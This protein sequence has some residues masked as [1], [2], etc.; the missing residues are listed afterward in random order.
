MMTRWRWRW[1]R[2]ERASTNWKF[3]FIH[4]FNSS[5]F[6]P[7]PS[8]I[9]ATVISGMK[10]ICIERSFAV[11]SES[12]REKMLQMAFVWRWAV[13]ERNAVTGS[14]ALFR[15]N[16]KA[17]S[18]SSRLI[19]NS[20]YLFVVVRRCRADPSS[21]EL[22]KTK[23]PHLA[24]ENA[25]KWEVIFY[26]ATSTFLLFFFPFLIKCEPR[27]CDLWRCTS[28]LYGIFLIFHSTKRV[29]SS[30]HEERNSMAHSANTTQ[31]QKKLIIHC[32]CID[33]VARRSNTEW[34]SWFPIRRI[35]L[36]AH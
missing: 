9:E 4:G 32:E 13:W 26:S 16:S 20:S 23:F 25:R 29:E 15:Q 7:S 18:T 11:L 22:L 27:I 31:P 5:I 21:F 35:A 14:S 30:R 10:G 17:S 36:A 1:R 6:P 33:F 19:S 12:R 2:I 8:A 3:A 28:H 24:M 34:D